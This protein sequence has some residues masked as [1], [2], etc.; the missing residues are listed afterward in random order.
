MGRP[1]I[2]ATVGQ[3]VSLRLSDEDKA[4]VERVAREMGVS[5]SEALRALPKIW[6]VLTEKQRRSLT[7]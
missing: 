5:V 3:V 6:D 2:S 7:K 1:R 4:E